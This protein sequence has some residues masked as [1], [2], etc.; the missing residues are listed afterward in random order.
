MINSLQKNSIMSSGSGEDWTR[1]DPRK[2]T[3]SKNQLAHLLGG[4][5]G[6]RHPDDLKSEVR[7]TVKLLDQR[8]QYLC[9]DVALFLCHDFLS[10]DE[11]PEAWDALSNIDRNDPLF[12]PPRAIAGATPREID[13]LQV[14]IQLGQ[15]SRMLYSVAPEFEKDRIALGMILGLSGGWMHEEWTMDPSI[16]SFSKDLPTPD[17]GVEMLRMVSDED[18]EALRSAVSAIQESLV[19]PPLLSPDLR[20][21]YEGLKEADVT[22]TGPLFQHARDR[23]RDTESVGTVDG[24]VE[25]L[26]QDATLKATEKF[27]RLVEE[28]IHELADH[29]YLKGEAIE[30]FSAIYVNGGMENRG[31]IR[32]MVDTGGQQISK[33]RNDFEDREPFA[34]RPLL[35]HDSLRNIW[36]LTPY[37][38]F[39]AELVVI[40]SDEIE[41]RL[42]SAHS[43][44]EKCHAE[45]LGLEGQEAQNRIESLLDQFEVTP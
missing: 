5:T 9:E 25:Q 37:G 35:E 22:L 13:Y 39:L 18:L 8:L 31:E 42:P 33:F 26:E 44:L 12:N 32:E 34:D 11:W 45:I 4:D 20:R 10:K 1:E 7:D 17:T 36:T 24:L 43:I 21:L 29:V 19:R 40:D 41:W 38:G 15:L 16:Q 27:A 6:T 2:F 23:Y 28:D 14:A 30:V 3:L